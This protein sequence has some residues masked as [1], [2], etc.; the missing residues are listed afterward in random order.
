MIYLTCSAESWI[1]IVEAL[2]AVAA[3]VLWFLSATV[4]IPSTAVIDLNIGDLGEVGK[5]FGRQSKLNAC[6]VTCAGIAALLSAAPIVTPTCLN[7][8]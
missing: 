8:G 2:F 4:R 6:A 7:L 3:A 5:A 1:E